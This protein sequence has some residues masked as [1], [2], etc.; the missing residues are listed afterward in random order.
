MWL[1]THVRGALARAV[2]VLANREHLFKGSLLIF[3]LSSTPHFLI[4]W[5]NEAYIEQCVIAENAVFI[6]G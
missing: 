3:G 4:V 1:T 2:V 5:R 6:L